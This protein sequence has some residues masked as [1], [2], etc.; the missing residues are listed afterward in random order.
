MK[1]LRDFFALLFGAHVGKVH[2]LAVARRMVPCVGGDLVPLS[3]LAFHGVDPIA[4]NSIANGEE[5]GFRSIV[6]QHVEQL[7]GVVPWAVVERERHDLFALRVGVAALH[8]GID[9][10][11]CYLDDLLFSRNLAGFDRA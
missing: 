10:V 11:A 6:A 3:D 9:G 5:R 7:V 4:R 2:A 1:A 8:N